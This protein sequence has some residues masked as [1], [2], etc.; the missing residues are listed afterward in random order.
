MLRLSNVSSI[1]EFSPA[2][3]HTLPARREETKTRHGGLVS[4]VI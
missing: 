3:G 1:A 4:N 2:E